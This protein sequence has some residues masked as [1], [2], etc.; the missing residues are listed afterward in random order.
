MHAHRP[1]RRTVLACA[2]ALA[3]CAT[4]GASRA[5]LGGPSLSPAAEVGAAPAGAPALAVERRGPKAYLALCAGAPRR[6]LAVRLWDGSALAPLGAPLSGAGSCAGAALRLD[7]SGAPVVAVEEQDAAGGARVRVL[8]WD[9]RAWQPLGAELNQEPQERAE[10][11]A[12]A[13]GPDGALWAAWQ[14]SR[15]DAVLVLVARHDG[16]AWRQ[17]GHAVNGS[18]SPAGS[19]APAIVIEPRGRPVVAWQEAGELAVRVA[20]HDGD[21]WRDLGPLHER[22]ATGRAPTLAL[23]PAGHVLAAFVLERGDERTVPV[24][25]WDGRGWGDVGEPLPAG[26]TSPAVTRPAIGIDRWGIPAVVV[27]RG[28]PS[29][30][31]L[32]ARWGGDGW[33]APEARLDVEGGVSPALGVTGDGNLVAAWQEQP[34]DPARSRVLWRRGPPPS[35]APAAASERP[36]P[37]EAGDEGR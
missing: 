11:P 8:R 35:A 22:G 1:F 26:R 3:G 37:A 23:D 28:G 14:E 25:R 7:Q 31:L 30:A 2:A 6:D 10:A 19:G 33:G 21:E 4:A 29:P 27:P 17:V 34:E 9:G 18:P 15:G 36:E 20:R 13:L 12:L 16:T 32:L 5:P 24:L